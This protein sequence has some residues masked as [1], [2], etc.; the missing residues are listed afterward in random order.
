MPGL[1]G[2]IRSK[3]L[4]IL[5]PDVKNNPYATAMKFPDES[6]R[7]FDGELKLLL[8]DGSILFLQCYIEAAS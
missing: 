2:I 7:L 1:V 6:A 3:T 8:M 5:T 4:P